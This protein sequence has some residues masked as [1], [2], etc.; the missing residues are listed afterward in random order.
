MK[1]MKNFRFSNAYTYDTIKNQKNKS[2]VKK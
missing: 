2:Q 1:T